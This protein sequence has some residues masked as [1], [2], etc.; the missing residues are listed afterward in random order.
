MV[1]ILRCT[2]F[3]ICRGFCKSKFSY[4]TEDDMLSYRLSSK[5]HENG[6]FRYTDHFL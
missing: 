4:E 1:F 3:L 2:K 5:E 6:V